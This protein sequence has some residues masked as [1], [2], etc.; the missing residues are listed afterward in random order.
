VTIHV[1]NASIPKRDRGT[2]LIPGTNIPRSYQTLKQW[3][4]FFMLCLSALVCSLRQS[5]RRRYLIKVC[6]H[7]RRE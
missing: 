2:D 5:M 1:L 4:L 7:R 3:L 6:A